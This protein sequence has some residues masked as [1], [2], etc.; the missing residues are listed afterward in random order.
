MIMALL[1]SDDWDAAQALAAIPFVN[2]FLEERVELERRAIGRRY[3]GVGPVLTLRPGLTGDEMYPELPALRERSEELFAKLSKKLD[4]ARDV[5]PMELGVYEGLAFLL[6]YLRFTREFE[7]LALS[8]AN[9][10]SGE[11]KV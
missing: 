5:A 10:T 1:P 2:P 3:L 8:L 6:I 4:K 9:S 11:I 7:S